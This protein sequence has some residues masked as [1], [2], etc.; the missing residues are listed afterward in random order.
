[1]IKSHKNKSII[2]FLSLVDNFNPYWFVT[3]MGTGSSSCILHDFPFPGLWL[4]ICSYV[5]FG[6]CAFLFITLQTALVINILRKVYFKRL[7]I[8]QIFYGFFIKS[9]TNLYWGTYS[10]G[11]CSIINYIFL[12]LK[13]STNTTNYERSNTFIIGIYVLWWA[14]LIL[15]LIVAWGL[16]ILHWKFN[17]KNDTSFLKTPIYL[18]PVVSIVVICSCGAQ[19]TMSDLFI[20]QF[21]RNVQLLTLVIIAMCWLQAIT[22]V[23]LVTA[24][25]FW[26]L[27]VNGMP[28]MVSNTSTCFLCVGPMGQGSY[29]I[30]LLCSDVVRYIELHYLDTTTTL[31][32]ISFFKILG[33][34]LGLWLISCGLFF[35]IYS[36]SSIFLFINKTKIH[37][38]QKSWWA[39]PFP[40]GTM[41]LST[42]ELWVQYGAF[43]DIRAFRIISVFFAILC[44]GST[45]LCLIG[46][47]N[48]YIFKQPIRK[49]DY[50][51]N[52]TI[53]HIICKHDEG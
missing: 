33:G 20:Y 10:M 30:Q 28:D 45:M 46:T 38:Y 6:I 43:I 24:V 39:M 23:F 48:H 1:M 3:V 37:N 49:K 2:L 35:V 18:L 25:Y 34:I 36:V 12:I 44:I 8:P 41:A 53:E 22:M 27:Y 47:C 16:T 50:D 21:N 31:I 26:N 7:R 42:K 11:I 15:S 17:N 32:A 4:R 29:G 19:I 13:S 51:I 52:I 9:P 5:M 14:G 40:L